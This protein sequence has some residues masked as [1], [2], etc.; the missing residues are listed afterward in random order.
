MASSWEYLPKGTSV[1][2][3]GYWFP[4]DR[5]GP[6]ANDLMVNLTGGSN[7]V[8]SHLFIDY[9]LDI[10]NALENYSY[11]GYMQPLTGVTAPRLVA[12]KLLPRSLASTVV[13]PEYF[14]DGVQQLELSEA[15]DADW[16]ITWNSFSEGL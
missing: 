7:P 4:P 6:I 5:R 10:S 13:L 9:L 16:E 11:V 1:D 8:L 12:E 14:R 15:A 2:V 3:I